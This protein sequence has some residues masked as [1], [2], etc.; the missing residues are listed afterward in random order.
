MIMGM[1]INGVNCLFV[2][3]H[4]EWLKKGHSYLTTE[5]PY[6]CDLWVR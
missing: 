4:V 1:L 6:H 3:G 5:D 2:D